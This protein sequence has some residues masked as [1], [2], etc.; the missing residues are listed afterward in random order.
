[1]A[2]QC[3]FEVD[4]L[5]Y[6]VLN[7]SY[8]ANRD[9]DRTGR[10]ASVLY[11]LKI[12]LEVEHTPSCILLHDWVFK[13]HEAK[14]GK[15]TFMKRDN[16]QKQTEIKFQDG[17]IVSIVTGFSNIGENPMS[18]KIEICANKYEFESDGKFTQYEL[19]WAV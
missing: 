17:Y 1:M 14:N 10:P 12:F 19:N 8:R 13:N 5:T 15:I 11:G 4:G 7:F 9:Y 2:F 6:N 3:I 18:E 16:M